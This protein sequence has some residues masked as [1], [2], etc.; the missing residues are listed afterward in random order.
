MPPRFTGAA[1]SIYS[2]TR[3]MKTDN[4]FFIPTAWAG[5]VLPSKRSENFVWSVKAATGLS[6]PTARPQ[7]APSINIVSGRTLPML[8][9][10]H[11]GYLLGVFANEKRFWKPRAYRPMGHRGT[12]NFSGLYGRFNQL[13]AM[14]GRVRCPGSR[15]SPVSAFRAVHSKQGNINAKEK[16][17][18]AWDV[19]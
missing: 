11:E 1:G 16:K 13:P 15:F 4:V 2:E 18:A 19:D 3:E 10:L 7:T 17:K 5:A 8:D 12:I 14:C 6:L 9:N